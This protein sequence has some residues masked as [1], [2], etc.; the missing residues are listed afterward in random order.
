MTTLIFYT[1][2]NAFYC[3]VLNAR[4]NNFRVFFHVFCHPTFICSLRLSHICC[5]NKWVMKT[6]YRVIFWASNK[7]PT[8][9]IR[10]DQQYPDIREKNCAFYSRTFTVTVT[11]SLEHIFSVGYILILIFYLPTAGQISRRG[12]QRAWKA[13]S[14]E[15]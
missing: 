9:F 6:I 12:R 13:W 15:S 14:K 1:L 11:N 10:R 8:R 2:L 5:K 3:T 4:L 7:Q